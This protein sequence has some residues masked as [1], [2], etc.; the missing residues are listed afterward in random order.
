MIPLLLA[1]LLPA[2]LAVCISYQWLRQLKKVQKLREELISIQ[3][4]LEHAERRIEDVERLSDLF[5]AVSA[6]AL[7]NASTSFID[8]ATAKFEKLQEGA[9]LELNHREKTIHDLVKPIKE[10]LTEVDK[11]I[12]ELDKGHLAS[13]Q[14]LV[15]QLKAVGSACSNLHVETTQLARA[16]RTPHVR[17]R[18]GEI[19]LRRV[20]E[21]AGMIPYCD[22][23]EQQ[24]GEVEERRLRADLIIRLPNKRHIV[25]DA[26][27][28]LHAYL[29][30][31]QES[32]EDIKLERLKDHARHLRTHI[33]DLSAKSYWEQYSPAPEFVVLF[34]PGEAFFSAALEQDPGLIEVGAQQKV[35]L[36]TP[37]TLIALLRA[38]AYGWRQDALAENSKAV[39]QLGREL[40]TRLSKMTEHFEGLRR[41]LEHAVDGYNRAIGSFESRVLVSARKFTDLEV[42]VDEELNRLELI[43][44]APR[45]ILESLHGAH[46]TGAQDL[47]P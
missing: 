5:K 42:T 19:Q 44:K 33:A 34:I 22:F 26:K 46:D 14:G 2:L 40:F 1:F 8:L 6:D 39:V 17:G 4:D 25:I 11:K 37:T 3:K 18:W 35:I 13:Y 10:S 38:V 32:K 21:L 7:K 9:R 12:A 24:T 43:E 30:A 47:D 15:E 23:I 41:G 31:M 28:P 16:L 45:Q 27:S 36:A 29:D 20:V